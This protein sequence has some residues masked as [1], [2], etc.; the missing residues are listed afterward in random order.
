MGG[1]KTKS[2]NICCRTSRRIRFSEQKW[3]RFK[4]KQIQ[5]RCKCNTSVCQDANVKSVEDQLIDIHLLDNIGI[6][7]INNEWNATKKTTL[8]TWSKDKLG[9]ASNTTKLTSINIKDKTCNNLN[10]EKEAV[11]HSLDSTKHKIK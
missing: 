3:R 2:K 11:R 10:L 4:C 1:C 7:R 6:N 9:N 8:L 5:T